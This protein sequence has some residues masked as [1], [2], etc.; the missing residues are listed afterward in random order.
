MDWVEEE[1]RRALERKNPPPDFAG[2]IL[3]RKP[4][5]HWHRW[6]AAAAALVVLSGGGY[7]Y[8]LHRGMEAKRQVIMAVR[9]AAVKTSRIQAQVKELTR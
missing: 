3:R 4:G 8:R 2:R 9:I 1:L 6:I 7:G 5:A